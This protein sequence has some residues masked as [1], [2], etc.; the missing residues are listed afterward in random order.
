[1]DIVASSS[2]ETCFL[3]ISRIFHDWWKL[4]IRINVQMIYIYIQYTI[5]G[6]DNRDSLS[7]KALIYEIYTYEDSTIGASKQPFRVI[8]VAKAWGWIVS[9]RS[10]RV[11]YKPKSFGSWF[12][13]KKHLGNLVLFCFPSFSPV[14]FSSS[15]SSLNSFKR[16][17]HPRKFT[18]WPLQNDIW[19]ELS[20]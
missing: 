19:Q 4:Y 13:Y 10:W 14:I 6:Y 1:M 3:R 8:W 11:V 9:P 15:E 16:S 20:F 17:L 5:N 12:N 18:S 2:K 7:F